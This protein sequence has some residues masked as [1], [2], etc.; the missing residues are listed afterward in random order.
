MNLTDTIFGYKLT[1][2]ICNWI[3]WWRFFVTD[4]IIIPP[5][6]G[7]RSLVCEP[8]DIQHKGETGIKAASCLYLYLLLILLLKS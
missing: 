6:L 5:G 2:I 4:V 3:P 8:G 1:E 7:L